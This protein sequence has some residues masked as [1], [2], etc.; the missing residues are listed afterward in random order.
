MTKKASL[1]IAPVALFY[2]SFFSTVYF[3]SNPGTTFSPP[4]TF[5]F[6]PAATASVAP[7]QPRP[8]TVLVVPGHDVNKGGAQ[9]RNLFERDLVAIIAGKIARIFSGNASYKIVVARD[10]LMWN[11]VLSD[12]F[13]SREQSIIDFKIDHKDINR[14]LME[15]GRKY[16]VPDMAEHPDADKTTIIQLYGINKW[17]GENDVDLVVHLHFNDRGRANLNAPGENRGFAIYIPERQ[18]PNATASRKAAEKIYSKLDTILTPESIG[19]LKESI[20]EDQSLIAVG[21]SDTLATPSML[22][23]YGYIYEKMLQTEEERERALTTMAEQTA[24]GIQEYAEST[25]E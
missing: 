3:L 7:I 9:Y 12:Y 13:K 17:V 5:T 21:A 18:M 23:E 16:F 19:N 11:P 14:A 15:L 10:R 20:V 24:L 6:L 25:R 8:F 1:Y 22:I 2:I 4:S